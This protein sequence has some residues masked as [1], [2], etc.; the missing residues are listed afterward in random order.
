MH[1]NL[2]LIIYFLYK[3][4]GVF[5]LFFDEITQS[6]GQDFNALKSFSFYCVANQ[7]LVL[8]GHNEIILCTSCKIVLKCNKKTLFVYG[9][10]LKIVSMSNTHFLIK[11][12]IWVIGDREVNIC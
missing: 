4:G 9:Q 6:L 7:G 12:D 3:N 8:N 10:N 1:I 5:C 2:K 11:G